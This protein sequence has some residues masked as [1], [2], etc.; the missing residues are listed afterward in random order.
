MGY[1]GAT[2]KGS[3]TFGGKRYTLWGWLT[4]SDR[5]KDKEGKDQRLNKLRESNLVR[6]EPRAG[7]VYAVW[8]HKK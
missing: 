7:G 5:R 2:A 1:R 4:S 8:T 3:K 6:V